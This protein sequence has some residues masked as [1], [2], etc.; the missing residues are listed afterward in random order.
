[1]DV[2]QEI[3][4]FT[5]DHRP[6]FITVLSSGKRLQTEINRPSRRALTSH[7]QEMSWITP[8]RVILMPIDKHENPF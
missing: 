2:W 7:C 1:M 4:R 5:P 8:L 3:V 6:T